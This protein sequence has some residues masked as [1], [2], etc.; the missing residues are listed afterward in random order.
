M[1]KPIILCDTAGMTNDRWLECRMHG[2]KGD[3]SYTV[4]GSDVA[5]IFGVS[6]WTT[7]LELWKIKKGQMKPAKKANANQ[8]YTVRLSIPQDMS[9]QP[10]PGMN[11]MVD[12]VISDT[13][14][15]K[16]EIPSS[17][18]FKKDGKSCVWV[19]NK[20]DGV[21]RLRAVSVKQLHTNGKAIIAQGL[22]DG[23]L[24]VTAGV[25]KLTDSPKVKP[26]ADES[27][28]NVGGLL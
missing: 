4:G 8:L 13:A 24:V 18:L 12:M 28:T 16:T 1:A 14:S 23:E 15:G 19:Y 17:A 10:S 27:E 3:I 22:S 26:M 2:P 21:I 25:H 7:P 20:K 9:P 6:P 5:A 11:T